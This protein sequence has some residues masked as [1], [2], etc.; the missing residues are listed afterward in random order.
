[1]KLDGRETPRET[2]LRIARERRV[3]RNWNT[4]TEA[5]QRVWYDELVR[6]VD[7]PEVLKQILEQ[8]P[9]HDYSEIGAGILGLLIAIVVTGGSLHAAYSSPVGG[10]YIIW[11]GRSC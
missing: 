6:T 4:L 7:Q 2:M 3:P 1:M 9:K 5:E 11:W 8:V 10:V